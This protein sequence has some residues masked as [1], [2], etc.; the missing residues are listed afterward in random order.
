MVK[1]GQSSY[2]KA[3]PS[4]RAKVK[5]PHSVSAPSHPH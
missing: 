4:G 3:R 2:I 5:N 1:P